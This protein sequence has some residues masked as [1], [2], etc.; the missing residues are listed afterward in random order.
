MMGGK[1]FDFVLPTENKENQGG[2]KRLGS[3][4]YFVQKV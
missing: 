4:A 3:D 2:G 1:T